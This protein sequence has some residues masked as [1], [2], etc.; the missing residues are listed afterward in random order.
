MTKLLGSLFTLTAL[1]SGSLAL[2]DETYLCT[3]KQDARVIEVIY[4]VE[5]QKLPCEVHYTKNGVA[6]KLWESGHTP[7]FCSAKAEDFVAQQIEWGWNCGDLASEQ[8]VS[9][10]QSSS[11]SQTAAITV[12]AVETIETEAAEPSATDPTALTPEQVDAYHLQARFS[13]A[14]ATASTFQTMV[15]MHWQMQGEYPKNLAELGYSGDQMQD[16]SAFADLKVTDGQIRLKGNEALG[17]GTA[18]LLTPKIT[19]AGNSMEWAC[20]TNVELIDQEI[21][22]LDN[23]ASF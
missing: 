18:I 10:L 4:P 12:E 6:Q 23:S 8:L 22:A 11:Q 15:S 2:A 9:E 14:L 16:S 3:H 5:H 17:T 19:L 21:C 1:F 13:Q 20:S 7:G